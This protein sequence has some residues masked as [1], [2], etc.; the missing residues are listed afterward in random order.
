MKYKCKI[1]KNISHNLILALFIIITSVVN[2]QEKA[3]LSGI[4]V[5][6]SGEPVIN[7][8]VVI[9]PYKIKPGGIRQEKFITHLVQQTD[10]DGSF[11]M[12]NIPPE[13]IKIQIGD[14]DTETKILSID[15]EGLTLF[16][17]ERP[18]FRMMLFSL[19]P[20]AKIEN[21][22]IK[23]KS[24]I[25]PQIRARVVAADGTPIAD[26]QVQTAINRNDIDRSG[27]GRSRG[28]RRTDSEGYFT[29][30]LRIDDEP[31]FYRIAIEHEGY[32]AVSDP[33]MPH[34]GQP[35]VHLL[36]KLNDKP[37]P[38]DDNTPERVTVEFNRLL[39][40]PAV[41]I[42]NPINGHDYKRIYCEGMEDALNQSNIEK[43]YLV[44][45]NDKIEEKWI[46]NITGMSECI[47]G[48]RYMVEE[49]KWKWHSGEPVTYTNWGNEKP[50]N[51]KIDM[52]DRVIVRSYGKWN[53]LSSNQHRGSPLIAVLEKENPKEKPKE[54][55]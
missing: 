30:K 51:E 45:I 36:L 46:E 8:G 15:L 22:I 52:Q 19:E 6:E 49:G 20:G 42:R 5:N 35:V 25:I 28:P 48:L 32:F 43:A 55:K 12:T 1:Q 16:P 2:A 53:L 11:T 44:S 10:I 34:E 29:E 31:Q 18:P 40:T 54:D 33:F 41:W 14:D 17:E 21:A 50:L 47:I 7:I 27:S 39:N 38:F 24:K 9:R 3:T 13:S 4:V 26:S 23:I 37:I